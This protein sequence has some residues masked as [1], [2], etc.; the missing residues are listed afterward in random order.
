MVFQ[1][2]HSQTLAALAEVACD[3]TRALTSSERFDRLLE[4]LR[5]LVDSDAAS[6]MRLADDVL[7]PVATIGLSP[8]VMGRTFDPGEHPRLEAI[9]ASRDPVVFAPDDPRP[10]PFD[11]LV[12]DDWSAQSTVHFCMGCTLYDG[13]ELLGVLTLDALEAGRIDRVDRTSMKAFASMAA[14]ALRSAELI[15]RLEHAAEHC[16]QVAQ[17]LVEE[18]LRRRGGGLL[19]QTEEMVRVRREIEVVAPTDLAVLVTG[20]TGTGKEIVARSLHARSTRSKEPLVYVNCA[21]LPESIAESELFGHVRGAFTGAARDRMGKFELAHKAT[22]FLDEVGELPLAIQTKLLRALQFGEVQRVGSDRHQIVDVRIIAATNRHLLAE[23]ESGR[24][25]DDL[26]HRLNAYPIHVPAL[27]DR[28]DDVLMLAGHLLD[29]ARIRLGLGRIRM[30][31]EAQRRLVRYD[32]PGNVR[33]LDHTLMRAA[34]RS[35]GGRRG[36][37]VAIGPA[38]LADLAVTDRRVGEEP[39]PLETLSPTLAFAGPED[40]PE[41]TLA[42]RVK[43]FKRRVIQDTVHSTDGNWSKASRQLGVDRGNLYKT[44]QRLDLV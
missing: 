33:E 6:L 43:A 7:N 35:S 31:P 2:Q 16:G 18:E 19:G 40:D 1:Q 23:I 8:D 3:L 9:L 21:A 11:G 22:L 39:R 28:K 29:R 13:D 20:E 37:E 10:D 25:R 34:L 17:S 15:E 14:A 5:R 4:A 12:A 41:L 27:R 42:E 44:A 30:T 36:E 38:D 32:W 24:F 26:F